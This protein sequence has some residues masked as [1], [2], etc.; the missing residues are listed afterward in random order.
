[1]KNIIGILSSKKT[2]LGIEQN[3]GNIF[4]TIHQILL[5]SL[6]IERL[7]ALELTVYKMFHATFHN[8]VQ[9]TTQKEYFMKLKANNSS[10]QSEFIFLG[11]GLNVLIR[12]NKYMG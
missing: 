1:M 3:K 9:R 10:I 11:S 8:I 4:T 2:Q 7:I 6:K 12:Y 5:E